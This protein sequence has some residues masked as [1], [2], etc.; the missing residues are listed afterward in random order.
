MM[1]DPADIEMISV[2]LPVYNGARYLERAVSSVL[3]Q[4]YDNFELIITDDASDDGTDE[5]CR[6]LAG[7]DNRISVT[8]NIQNSGVL[9]TRH[10][11]VQ[12]AKGEWIA[13][14]DADDKWHP[15]KLDKQIVLRNRTGCDLVYTASSFAD[16]NGNDYD[17]IMH[18]PANVTYK[19]LLKQNI[20]SNSSVL[21]RRSDYLCYAPSADL[22]MDIHE[23]YACWLQML[24]AGLTACGID[25]P[26]ITYMISKGS[27]TGNKFRSASMNMNTYKYTGL[28][29]F[30]RLYYEACY[31]ANGILKHRHFVKGR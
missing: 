27:K 15:E 2:I 30:G 28:G 23:D 9:V 1:T 21:M 14:I 16:E 24:K 6:R 10:R 17:W 20:I 8:T 19:R 22:S 5:I 26:L 25:E 12:R 7:Q 18:V 4:T 31:A 29:F 3:R 13:F 11:A